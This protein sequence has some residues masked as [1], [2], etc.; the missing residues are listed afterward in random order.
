[1]I[2][3][4]TTKRVNRGFFVVNYSQIC[5]PRKKNQL[6]TVNQKKKSVDRFG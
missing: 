5:Q 2:I 3:I 4:S 6:S 1:M